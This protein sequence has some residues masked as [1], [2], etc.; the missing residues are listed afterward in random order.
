MKSNKPLNTIYQMKQ[1]K[2]VV[3]T[4]VTREEGSKSST[5]AIKLKK[6]MESSN[7]NN[8]RVVERTLVSSHQQKMSK[9]NNNNSTTAARKIEANAG[10]K[11]DVGLTRLRVILQRTTEKDQEEEDE[12]VHYM[13]KYSPATM[14][15]FGLDLKHQQDSGQKVA[16]TKLNKYLLGL[17]TQS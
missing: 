6:K 15:M 4:K 1:K 9:C 8:I 11:E 5:T 16:P 10:K 2:S 14:K 17:V 13:V 7:N 12:L 3:Q